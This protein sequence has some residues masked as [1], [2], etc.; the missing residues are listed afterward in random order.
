[1]PGKT[2]PS[3]DKDA[4]C[5]FKANSIV[6]FALE[7]QVLEVGEWRHNDP[8]RNCVSRTNMTVRATIA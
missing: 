8:N 7:R 2:F 3:M 1:M 4:Y 6:E 5:D